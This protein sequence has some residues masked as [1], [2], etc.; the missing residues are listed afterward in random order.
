MFF[1]MKTKL[2]IFII[3][4]LLIISCRADAEKLA[5][6][7]S[8]LAVGS[9]FLGLGRTGTAAKLDA[10]LLFL[11]PAGLAGLKDWQIT[12]MY[13]KLFDEVDYKNF[14]FAMPFNG[15]GLGAGFI[16]TNVN[17]ILITGRDPVTG[18]IIPVGGTIDY[19][20]NLVLTGVG[21][22][23]KFKIGQFEIKDELDIGAV[24]KYFNENVTGTM[25]A[26][27]MG[28]EMDMGMRYTPVTWLSFGFS[29]RNFLPF[30]A[31]SI[32]WTTGLRES[33]PMNTR[34][35][36]GLKLLG[37]KGLLYFRGQ[38]LWVYYDLER[39]N[40]IPELSFNHFG[41]EWFPLE[42]L[43]LR[44]GIDDILSSSKTGV[45]KATNLS[46]GVTLSVSKFSFDYAFHQF[47][48]ID[49]LSTHFLALCYNREIVEKEPP[50]EVVEEKWT[51]LY[52]QYMN[53][54]GLRITGE[55]LK[56]EDIPYVLGVEIG[57][58]EFSFDGVGKIDLF[59][60]L[61]E[62]GLI[63]MDAIVF[64]ESKRFLEVKE[65][66]F[67]NLPE[68]KDVPKDS[69]A[70]A[71]IGVSA[72]L[73]YVKGFPDETFR[74]LGNITRAEM[75]ALLLRISEKEILVPMGIFT[76]V[77]AEHWAASYIRSGFKYQYFKGYPDGSFRP[78]SNIS[79]AEGIRMISNFAELL[80]PDYVY[81]KP[82]D[83]ISLMHWAVREI[84]IAKREGLLKL[85]DENNLYPNV[86]LTRVEVVDMLSRTD[87]VKK[88]ALDVLA[89]KPEVWLDGE[90]VWI[91]K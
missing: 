53:F 14:V 12:S 71:K 20:N 90:E 85:F 37:Y 82:F 83:D 39:Q 32:Y 54:G 36:F 59:L 55:V 15:V 47:Y 51:D 74:P 40:H 19:N 61:E 33:V 11:N 91:R 6:D 81:E 44:F 43:G 5:V 80:L 2:I 7:P 21:F 22:K 65:V 70:R 42:S 67:V 78:G 84:F 77:S 72:V 9:R 66:T 75:A 26:T 10:S 46:F 52:Y 28:F 63:T 87:I 27:A 24:L 30:P 38:D 31:G 1:N 89:L 79:R 25:G 48:G 73:G 86:S 50:K 8:I 62:Y 23:P 76:D 56:K 45:E 69:R 35:G 29:A 41:I 3:S 49:V 17:N 34:L 16:L 60:P 18:R 58:E 88:K 68:F 13:G 64:S 4:L 57:G